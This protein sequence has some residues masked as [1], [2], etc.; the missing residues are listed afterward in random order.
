MLCHRAVTY[1]L[2]WP[3]TIVTAS[4]VLMI[5]VAALAM[6]WAHNG[7]LLSR[8]WRLFGGGVIAFVAVV[9]ALSGIVNTGIHRIQ[10]RRW[11]CVHPGADAARPP[12]SSPC[13]ALYCCH[14]AVA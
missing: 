7:F 12:S 8:S 11:C 9:S 6:R 3:V 2:A 4:Y 5:I 13:P 1:A 10:V 14:D